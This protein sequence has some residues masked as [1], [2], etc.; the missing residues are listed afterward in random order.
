MP[1]S[2]LV[3]KGIVEAGIYSVRVV[4]VRGERRRKIGDVVVDVRRHEVRR[5][6]QERHRCPARVPRGVLAAA[7]PALGSVPPQ[8]P[9]GAPPRRSGVAPAPEVELPAW[10]P[11][12]EPFGL[13]AALFFG[14]IAVAL[15]AL[16][17]MAVA[18]AR[19]LR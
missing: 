6:P 14:A 15:I 2:A 1:A 4:A 3:R 9:E 11:F 10:L 8:P 7:G 16:A 19:A 18:V 13:P 17:G 5:L 12:E